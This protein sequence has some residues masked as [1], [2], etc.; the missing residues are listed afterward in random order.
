MTHFFRTPSAYQCL[1]DQLSIIY[2]A[3]S[4]GTRDNGRHSVTKAT[5]TTLLATTITS[6]G[7]ASWKT[8]SE[9]RRA[10]AVLVSCRESVELVPRLRTHLEAKQSTF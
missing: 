5:G 2:L 7:M 1:P 8:S 3:A 6:A 10:A 9:Q 4:A